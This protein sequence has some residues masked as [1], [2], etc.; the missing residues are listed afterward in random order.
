MQKLFGDQLR[1]ERKKQDLTAEMIAKACGI[2]RS[3]ITLI[4]SGKRQPGK[5]ILPKIAV[6]LH[7]NKS[8]VLDWYLVN[9][10]LSLGEG[11]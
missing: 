8:V 4:E 7:L 2:S 11:I 9:I 6:A 1:E 3:Y 5:R 10:K